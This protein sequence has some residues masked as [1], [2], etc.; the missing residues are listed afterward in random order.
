MNK[1]KETY[2]TSKHQSLF[3]KPYSLC[4][5]PYSLI[6]IF[7]FLFA[8]LFVSCFNPYSPK[9]NSAS[10]DTPPGYGAFTLRLAGSVART[11]LPQTPDVNDFTSYTLVFTPTGSGSAITETRTNATLSDPIILPIGSYTLT[12]TAF[13]DTPAVARSEPISVT[14]GSGSISATVLLKMLL[15]EGSGTFTWNI[16][17]GATAVNVSSVTMT[18]KNAS[19]VTQGSLETLTNTG[20]STGSR[21]LDSGKY[22]VDIVIEG[23]EGGVLKTVTWHEL[24]Y[25]YSGLTSNYTKTFTDDYFH[26]SYWNVT[27]DYNYAGGGSATQS[28]LHG[29]TMS[30]PS[31]VRPFTLTEGLYLGDAPYGYAID[32]WRL[33]GAA[34]VFGEP[35]LN[36][37]ILT[38]QWI[39]PVIDLTGAAGAN[40][41]EQAT[42]YINAGAANADAGTYTL[43][44]ENNY[45]VSARTINQDNFRLTII[46]MTSERTIQYS[47]ANSQKLFSINADN[48]SL[49]IGDKITLKGTASS[50]TN[51]VE[52][53]NGTFIMESGSTITGHATSSDSGTVF[54]YYGNA[55]FTMNGG[56]ISGN[57]CSFGSN[58]SSGGVYIYNGASFT[59]NGGSI[60]GNTVGSGDPID[61]YIASTVST[62]TL[63]GNAAIGAVMLTANS[64][65]NN[66]LSLGNWTPP[67]TA[68]L[69]LLGETGGVNMN[70]VIDYWQGKTVLRAAG[71]YTLTATDVGRFTLGNFFRNTDTPG[72]SIADTHKIANSGVDIGK[73]MVEQDGTAAY[74]WKVYN[75]DRLQKVGTETATRGWTRSAH[76]LQTAN[77]DMS[78]QSFTAISSSGEA[79]SG[80]YDGGGYTILNL[81]INATTDNQ[82]M[83]GVTN[84]SGAV[85]NLG[86]VDASITGGTYIGGIVGNNGGTVEHCYVTGSI[87]G[88]AVNTS[89]AVNIGGIAGRNAGT[90]RNCYTNCDVEPTPTLSGVNFGGIVGGNYGSVQNCYAVGAVSGGNGCGIAGSG[91]SGG[92]L[93]NC[94]ALNPVVKGAGCCRVQQNATGLINNYGREDM[95]VDTAPVTSTD[96]NG[97]HGRD[98]STV[99]YNTESWWKAAGT[100]NSASPWDFTNVWEWNNTTSLPILRGFTANGVTQGHTVQ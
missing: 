95:I 6:P 96:L 21:S 62:V 37:M 92:T 99:E 76:Y 30:A 52:V 63:S 34:Y 24:L 87:K 58:K 94:A 25:V 16:T 49:A 81:I 60:T 14:I 68:T 86:L 13:I 59:M 93:Q 84:L 46:G 54:V 3:P 91:Y 8:L 100:W 28:V 61:V 32:E 47:G 73:L 89:Y 39:S 74:P 70:T 44:L 69:H 72:Q 75:V 17:L 71:S 42:A 41:V 83:F 65:E 1:Y 15:T 79:F 35:V 45:N 48:A 29:D 57:H 23:D 64:T 51:L 50:T 38:A 36:D 2:N 40:I 88:G 55:H 26:R 85:R 27:F 19:G 77:I 56:T 66:Y 67:V 10:V 80:T 43:Y 22:T 78:G 7:S 12:V 53:R 82:G 18:I 5:N 33:G 11:I 90:V 97:V 31:P 20:T 98:V 9:P 4:S